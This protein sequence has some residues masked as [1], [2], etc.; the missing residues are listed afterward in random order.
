MHTIE[1]LVG[2][3][4][5]WLVF[6]AVAFGVPLGRS[7]TLPA[8]KLPPVVRALPAFSL[9]RED[10]RP[11]GTVDLAG[12]VW[13]ADTFV[14]GGAAPATARMAELERRMR[15]LGE[16]FHLVSFALGPTESARLAERAREL[17]A[18]P[19]RWT[20]LLGPPE[21]V[22]AVVDGLGAK[23]APDGRLYLIDSHSRLRGSYEAADSAALEELIYDAALLVN[24]Y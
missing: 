10:G 2:R 19:R 7:L 5:F 21:A 3:W 8:P 18:N 15:K 22:A 20:F 24:N 14:T 1:W 4:W 13:V 9:T 12:K 23:G 16:A 17:K 6:L 11:F